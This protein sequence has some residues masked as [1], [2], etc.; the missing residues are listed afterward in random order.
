MNYLAYKLYVHCN[1]HVP[2][3]VFWSL[4]LHKK[5][6]LASIYLVLP[7]GLW[8]EQVTPSLHISVYFESSWL[9]MYDILPSHG[10]I[11]RHS[12]SYE[13][14]PLSIALEVS[15]VLETTSHR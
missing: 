15:L 8:R 2:F 10:R 9:H 13:L 12:Q 5:L 3:L 1:S 14:V 4:E 7:C 6:R 11:S